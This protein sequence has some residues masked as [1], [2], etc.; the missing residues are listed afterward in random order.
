MQSWLIKRPFTGPSANLQAQSGVVPREQF[1]W[2]WAMGHPDD[3]SDVSDSD[4]STGDEDYRPFVSAFARCS[5]IKEAGVA[6]LF[7]RNL[8]FFLS[9][10]PSMSLKTMVSSFHVSTYIISIN[11]ST[12]LPIYLSIDLSNSLSLSVCLCLC[13][14]S[15][16]VCLCLSVSVCLCLSLSVSVCLCLSLSLSVCLCL[17]LSVSVCLCLC[18]SLS[19]S[20]CRSI[21][22]SISLSFFLSTFFL[23]TY[24]PLS[25]S[26]SL[27][28]DQS[29]Y[30]RISLSISLFI[31]LS[32]S[33]STFRSFFFSFFFSLF[34]SLSLSLS[35]R[36]SRNQTLSRNEDR[37]SQT[38]VNSNCVKG[39]SKPLR[40]TREVECQNNCCKIAFL[41]SVG[42]QNLR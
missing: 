29:L 7:S 16:S 1:C 9:K 23:L 35:C 2:F 42:S 30:L 33:L 27:S 21:S 38:A 41:Q 10:T 39:R 14:L 28:I 11:L 22:L 31:H 13:L 32:T 26:L 3:S 19:V 12:D 8:D 17:S 6:N 4:S 40:G 36:I 5:K 20:V 34:L 15:V 37:A 24:L 18:L 25:L